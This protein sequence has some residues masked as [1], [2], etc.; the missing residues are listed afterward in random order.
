MQKSPEGSFGLIPTGSLIAVTGA[1]GFIGTVLCRRLLEQGFQVRALVRNSSEGVKPV[2]RR[3]FLSVEGDLE[4]TSALS[5]TCRRLRFRDP[6]RRRCQ[7][8]F[9]GC[10]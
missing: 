2:R 6:R 3:A 9:P 5:A 1:T 7:G 10:I 4:N 8:K